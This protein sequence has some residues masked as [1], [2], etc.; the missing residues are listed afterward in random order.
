MV[1]DHFF[2]VFTA[3]LSLNM[4]ELAVIVPSLPVLFN[5]LCNLVPVSIPLSQ[6]GA[7]IHV[8]TWYCHILTAFC[9]LVYTQTRTHTVSEHFYYRHLFAKWQMS[10]GPSG[11][12]FTHKYTQLLFHWLYKYKQIYPRAKLTNFV[13][14]ENSLFNL[15]HIRPDF[16]YLLDYVTRWSK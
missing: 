5:K 16:F 15:Y 3:I 4:V 8:I 6:W 7:W 1:Y 9:F 11:P 2:E 14:F 13:A 12:M 10:S